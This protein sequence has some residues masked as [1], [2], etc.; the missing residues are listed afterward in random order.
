MN[1][2][3]RLAFEFVQALSNFIHI[4][5][6]YF[7]TKTVVRS[8]FI[9]MNNLYRLAFEFVYTQITLLLRLYI[10]VC[11]NF[12]PYEQ[13]LYQLASKFIARRLLSVNQDCLFEFH[14]L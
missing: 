5:K 2:L 12:I 9:H 3:Y 10:V 6:D 1:N 8:N 13:P 7:V 4:T 14:P 11:L